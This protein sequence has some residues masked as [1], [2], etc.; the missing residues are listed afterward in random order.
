MDRSREE[1]I[2][3]YCVDGVLE[4]IKTQLKPLIIHLA[5]GVIIP[6][7]LL[8]NAFIIP[9]PYSHPLI[10]VAV[11]PT[12]L[13][14]FLDDQELL[15]SLTMSIFGRIT[16]NYAPITILILMVFWFSVS[17]LLSVILF[18]IKKLRS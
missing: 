6:V 1:N 3:S 7:L 17:F 18:S 4:Q 11:A 8:A 13:M 15:K 5:I 2:A 14:P 12:H 16:P 9:E 10:K